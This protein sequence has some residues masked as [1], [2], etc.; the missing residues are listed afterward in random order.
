MAPPSPVPEAEAE[1]TASRPSFAAVPAKTSMVPPLPA[2]MPS[3]RMRAPPSTS[4]AVPARMSMR[5]PASPA[6]ERMRAF[7]PMV[8]LPPER[9]FTP[10]VLTAAAISASRLP[11]VTSPVTAISPP[12]R[13]LTPPTPR[14][15]PSI[16]IPAADCGAVPSTIAVTAA[17]FGR[18]SAPKKPERKPEVGVERWTA[19]PSIEPFASTTMPLELAK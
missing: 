7:D 8:V 11:A 12:V 2:P 10:P 14:T 16:A 13:R 3:A 19:P 4:I 6:S 9:I 17:A 15:A 5:P 1:I 18:P